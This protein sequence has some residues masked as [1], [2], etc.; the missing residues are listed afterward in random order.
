RRPI[1]PEWPRRYS[2]SWSLRGDETVIVTKGT[3]ARLCR[4]GGIACWE[5]SDTE[6]VGGLAPCRCVLDISVGNA[7]GNEAIAPYLG[8]FVAR[9]GC[10][11]KY[12]TARS[13]RDR[14][15]R[16][17]RCASLEQRDSDRA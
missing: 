6:T 16:S 9:V 12:K 13:R 3:K 15:R 17:F 11:L 7:G 4:L 5:R 14:C 1:R 10:N 2:R 8:V